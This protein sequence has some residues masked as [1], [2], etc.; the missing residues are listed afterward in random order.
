MKESEIRDNKVLQKYQKLVD[1][2]IKK[3]FSNKKNFKNINYK[4]WGCKKIIKIFEKKNFKYFQCTETKTIFANPRPKPIILEK[5]YSDT[6]SSKFWLNKFFLPKA[7]AR[8][9]KIVKPRVD[10]VLNNF[11]RCQSKKIFDVG[12]GSGVFLTE[13]RKKWPKVK[14]FALEPSKLMAEK[15]R[16]QNIKVIESTIEKMGTTNNKFDLITCFELFEHLYEPNLFLKK[17][18]KLL[19]KNGI[20]YLTTLNG[21]GFDIQLL[22]KNSNSIYPPYHINFFNPKSIELL[23]K[24]IGFKIL[25]VDTP[26]K[27]DLSIVENN[28]SLLKGEIKFF[29]KSLQKNTSKIYKEHFQ[30]FL[31]ENKLSSHM[32]VVVQK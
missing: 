17:I 28:F 31:Q 16:S 14:L 32:R 8:K 9:N 22:G 29:I 1:Q 4:S 5:F 13:L 30:K 6:K 20:F 3:I 19:N 21:M 15:C 2:D 18:Y 11:K 23:L 24:K 27:L 25:I 26:G 12:S 7:K 10:F